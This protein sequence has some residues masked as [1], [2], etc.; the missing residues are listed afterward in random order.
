MSESCFVTSVSRSILHRLAALTAVYLATVEV[1]SL[2]V[3]GPNTTL[4]SKDI[5][6]VRQALKLVLVWSIFVKCS[7]I[8]NMDMSR[9]ILVCVS[10]STEGSLSRYTDSC[11]LQ[12]VSGLD[13]PCQ[14]ANGWV[15]Y[16]DF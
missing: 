13:L 14:V 16:Q 8:I 7:S 4:L 15:N 3:S 5:G 10:M 9:D 6:I 12:D 2:S 1:F 11:L